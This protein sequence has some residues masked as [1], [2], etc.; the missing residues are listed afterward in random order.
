GRRLRGIAGR[1]RGV[2]RRRHGGGAYPARRHRRLR[3]HAAARRGLQEA[4]SRA[5]GQ[6]GPGA[7][8]GVAGRVHLLQAR[9]VGHGAKAGAGIWLPAR[10]AASLNQW[11]VSEVAIVPAMTYLSACSP[12]PSR[13]NSRR[14]SAPNWTP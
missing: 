12:P 9:G 5:V 11:T 6:V 2:V 13:S 4:G 8:A 10:A 14:P 1:E 7:G 3:L